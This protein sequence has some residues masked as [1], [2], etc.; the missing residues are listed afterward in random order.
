MPFALD[1][2]R[3]Q[4]RYYGR[5]LELSRYEYDLL[6]LLVQRPG[7]P[8]STRDEL[9][10]RVWDDATESLDRTVDA[11]VKTLRAKL[12]LVAPQ[13][14]PIRTHR[15]T[16][17]AL[18]RRK[19]P[20]HEDRSLNAEYRTQK[21]QRFRRSR[22]RKPSKVFWCFLRPLRS[23]CLCVRSKSNSSA[24]TVSV[25]RRTRIFIG[26]LLIY[27]AGIAFLLYRVV[28]DI[29]P[30]YRESAEESLV[31]ASQLMASLIEQDVIAG[32]IN[33]ARLEPLFR[34]VYTY[35][36]RWHR[37]AREFSAQIYNLHKT[38]SRVRVYVTDRIGAR[39]VRF[40]RQ[41]DLGADYSRWPD[42]ARSLAGQYGART[43]RDVASDPHT[44]P[45]LVGDVGTCRRLADPLGRRDPRR[46]G[47][48]SASRCGSFR[49]VR[50]GCPRRTLWVGVEL[51]GWRCCVLA[52]IIVSRSRPSVAG[53]ALRIAHLRLQMELACARASAA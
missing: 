40:A 17:Y 24:F 51:R 2:E 38:A 36:C 31:E 23:F 34:S 7:H 14:E 15:G 46:H 4:I 50:G 43:S 19:L 26:I 35:A 42:V 27:A 1:Q 11:H 10:E 49:P 6:R 25:T 21:S 20:T 30:R 12:K 52:I 37:S 9:L 3:M 13:L 28:I 5:L 53:A 48:A 33:T 41:R 8:S 39:G 22:K 29:D 32:A 44:S 45:H 18:E 47:H 16:G